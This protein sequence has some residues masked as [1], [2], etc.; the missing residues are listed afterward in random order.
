MKIPEIRLISATQYSF[1]VEGGGIP[2][3]GDSAEIFQP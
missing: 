1:S 3:E 2:L